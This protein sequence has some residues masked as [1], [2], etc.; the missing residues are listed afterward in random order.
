M[1]VGSTGLPVFANMMSCV[2]HAVRM[3]VHVLPAHLGV[4][5][6]EMGRDIAASAVSLARLLAGSW[7]FG[8]LLRFVRLHRL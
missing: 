6:R 5:L 4:H 2:T 3:N 7:G 8:R 1:L